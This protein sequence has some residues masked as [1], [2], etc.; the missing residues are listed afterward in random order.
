M[1]K[2][3]WLISGVEGYGVRRATLG[4]SGALR[5]SNVEV[6]FV[7]FRRGEFSNELDHNG[8]R[9]WFLSDKNLPDN[10]GV[11]PIK[12]IISVVR[13]VATQL[14][15]VRRLIELM[16]HDRPCWIH[17][18]NNNLLPLAGIVGKIMGIDVFWHLPNTI[19][20]KL[21][22]NLQALSYQIFCKLANVH[23]LGNS[24]HTAASLGR[25]FVDT[26]V[27]HLGVDAEYFKSTAQFNHYNRA[28]FG[29]IESLPVFAI[30]ARICVEKAQDRVVNAAIELLATGRRIQLLIVGGPESSGYYAHM[31]ESVSASGVEQYIKFVGPVVDPRPFYDLAD[32]VINSRAMAEPFGLT[33]VE[34]MLMGRPVLAYR[35]G[36][37][38]E[39]IED[40]RSGWLI[41][42]PSVS[43]YRDGLLRVLSDQ[44]NWAEMGEYARRTAN[45]RFSIVNVAG[46]YLNIVRRYVK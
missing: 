27:L 41:D 46:N 3:I 5:D 43:G 42:D 28:E 14:R 26:E 18:R 25:S 1:K 13:S 6:I 10:N 40:G 38:G 37:P 15:S 29:L 16:R 45:E 2:I 17:V 44:P 33:V 9:V 4:L 35:P 39:T 8:Y 31:R 11:G 36:G 23:P 12:Y 34:A 7:C 24:E 22:F 20:R 30:V 21:P 19:N 32:V